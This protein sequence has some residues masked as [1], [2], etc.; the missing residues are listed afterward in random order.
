M[1]QTRFATAVALAGVLMFGCGLLTGPDTGGSLAIERFQITPDR[2][3]NGAKATLLWSVEGA[4]TVSI[5]QDIGEVDSS[6]S[7]QVTPKATTTYTMTATGGTSSATATVVVVVGKPGSSPSP[8]PS[9]SSSPSPSP[10][11]SSSPSPSP[12]PSAGPVGSEKTCGLPLATVDGCKLMAEWPSALAAGECAQVTRLTAIPT[13]PVQVGM[14]RT[15][16]FDVTAQSGQAL[17][18]RRAAGGGDAVSPASG[19]LIAKG[20]STASTTAVVYDSS[21]SFEVV[22]ATGRVLM[23]FTLN[24]R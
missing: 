6:G 9:P 15:I 23:R 19:S 2:V 14:T 13:C 3:E 8:S 7:M 21:L 11:P 1:T 12:S 10:S 5:D 24:H 20:T 4:Q 18:W 16:S 17:S 22:D